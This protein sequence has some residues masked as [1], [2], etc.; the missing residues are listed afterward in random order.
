MGSRVA[1]STY[2]RQPSTGRPIGT[3]GD[4][5][6]APSSSRTAI[7]VT[8]PLTS[9]EPYRFRS[10]QRGTSSRNRAAT[11]AGSGSPL[12]VHT[13]SAARREARSAT[14]SSTTARCEGSSTIRLTRSR[15]SSPT[16]ACA[17]STTGSGTTTVGTPASSG[18]KISQIEST[19]L[20][21]VFWHA[22][23]PGAKGH[24]RHI[25]RQRLIVA[26]WPPTTPCARPVEPE[27]YMTYAPGSAPSS[28]F[29][30]SAPVPRPGRGAPAAVG[31]ADA[32]SASIPSGS[33]SPHASR[34]PAS[35]STSASRAPQSP[36]IR[37]R[38]AAG[39]A[40]SIGTKRAPARSVPRRAGYIAAERPRH[41]A[42]ASPRPTPRATR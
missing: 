4:A 40:G 15:S 35:P 21:E 20:D 9:V 37:A 25:Q 11:P 30:S 6:S 38:R 17:S 1:S 41:S 3:I 5:S 28:A 2:T 34:A 29:A 18:P 12:T 39:Y 7:A 24:A 19:K 42:T 36:S 22:T 8:S 16:S 10:S 32:R 14:P 27:V 23:S 31:G 33:T 26:A 13:R